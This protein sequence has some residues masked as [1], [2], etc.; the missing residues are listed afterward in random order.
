MSKTKKKS[1]PPA[2]LS[3]EDYAR[4]REQITI[5]AYPA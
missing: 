2:V 1:P 3:A 4:F 5:R